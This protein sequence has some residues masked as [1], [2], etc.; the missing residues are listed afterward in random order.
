MAD[1]IHT[2]LGAGRRVAIPSEL[3]RRYGIEPG[4][5][6]VLELSDSGIVMR[7]LGAVIREVQAYFADVAPPGVSLSEELLR[8]R[9]EEAE[10]E[11]HG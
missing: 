11:D 2:K 6:V 10:R 9:R 5:P 1:V 8:D 4:D 7:P 3:C